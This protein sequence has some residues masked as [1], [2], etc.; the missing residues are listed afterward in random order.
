[1]FEAL[2]QKLDGV[3]HRLSGRGRISESNVRD[4]MRDVRTALLEADVNLRVVRTFCDDVLQ[5]AIG[6]VVDKAIRQ[7]D[8]LMKKIVYDELVATMGPVDTQIH[9]VTPVTV[10]MLAGLQGS[11][12]TTTCAKL[13]R[14]L[15]S[16]GK[17]PM[18]VAAD[19]QR[20]A[21]IEQLSVL[22]GQIDVPV[23]REDGA[24]DPVKVCQNAVKEAKR[25]DRDVL[26]LD[27]AGR[28]HIDVDLM[29]QLREIDQKVNPHAI[30]LVCDA[31]TGQDAVNSA[32]EFNAQLELDGVI[33]TKLDG[34]ARGGAALSVKAVTGKPIKFIGEGEK[35]DRLSEFRPEGMA[36]RILGEGD[37]MEVVTRVQGVI[38]AEDAKKAQE[39]LLKGR[40]TLD[41]FMNQ[42]GSMKG[43]GVKDMIKLMPGLGRQMAGMDMDER[44]IDHTRAIIQSMTRRE[45]EDP[46][47]ID[48]SRRRR[49]AAGSGT[50][51]ADVSGLIKSF[52][53]IRHFMRQMQSAGPLG[54]LKM[55]KQFGNMDMFQKGGPKFKQ[56]QRSKR[57][58]QPR[59]RR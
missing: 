33:L 21:A 15:K 3:F 53:Q 26:L 58:R 46:D 17:R 30:Y 45:R 59:K 52:E 7:P 14:L 9:Y 39:K 29:A 36:S 43:V 55:M 37:I 1:M 19:L 23:H 40:F 47:V 25:L 48:G 49:I 5:K 51:P 44:E 2:T 32:K 56:R 13:A 35:L 28:L 41:D 42:M 24:T 31:M 16:R 12:K 57:K 34:D 27:T 18:M 6:Q 20:P 22:G 8:A 11:G 50:E 54:R 10:L 38:S 4:A